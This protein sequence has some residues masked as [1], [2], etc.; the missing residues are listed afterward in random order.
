MS[1]PEPNASTSDES[2]CGVV[3]GG[4]FV[5]SFI[6]FLGCTFLGAVAHETHLEWDKAVRY[7]FGDA[8]KELTLAERQRLGQEVQRL[9]RSTWQLGVLLRA[10]GSFALLLVVGGA[11]VALSRRT[12]AGQ[13]SRFWGWLAATSPALLLGIGVIGTEV[14]ESWWKDEEKSL[15]ATLGTSA[16][17]LS[18]ALVIGA[19]YVFIAWRGLAAKI[20]ALLAALTAIPLSLWGMKWVLRAL[21][22]LPIDPDFDRTTLARSVAGLAAG[23]LGTTLC[24][25]LVALWK[26]RR[27]EPGTKDVHR[28]S[29]PRTGTFRVR[30]PCGEEIDVGLG[31][32]SNEVDCLLCG[33]RLVIPLATPIGGDSPTG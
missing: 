21:E 9:R 11:M 29:D 4:A 19:I 1:N 7:Y 8:R 20:V 10:L 25:G 23:L 26:Q 6:L 18:A 2:G 12:P 33:N 22:I 13:I 16:V 27:G 31:L 15:F 17:V 28:T 14:V 24:F 32:A 3:Y 5:L 30:C